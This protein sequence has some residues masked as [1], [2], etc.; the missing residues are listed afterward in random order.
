MKTTTQGLSIIVPSY[1]E[2]HTVETLVQ[3]IADVL[4]RSDTPYEIIFVDDHSK[5]ATKQKI[6]NLV[7][8]YPIKVFTK[9]GKRGKAYSITEGATHA[10][11]EY[12]AMLDADLQ[13]PPEALPALFA[14]AQKK[15]M[16]VAYRK[17]YRTT[18]LRRIASRL[19][20]FIFG[21]LLLDLNTDVQSGL[22]IF[23]REIF[24][25]LNRRLVS[26]WA[27]DM[28]LL[29]TGYELGFTI[30]HVNIDFHPRISGESHVQLFETAKQ[31]AMGAIKTKLSRRR[32]FSL[33]PH[34]KDT[35]RGAG[36]AHR[37]QRFITHTTLPHHISAFTTLTRWQKIFLGLL[38]LVIGFNLIS[39]PLTT[40]IVIVGVLSAVYFI[41]VLFNL[42]LILKSLHFPPEISIDAQELLNLKDRDLP[43]YSILCPLYREANILPQFVQ[44]IKSLDWLEE[45][46]DILLLLEEDDRATIDAA[47]VMKLP[48]SMRIVVVPHSEPKTKPKASNYG[49]SLVKGEYVVVYDAE[50]IPDP[51]QL[52]KAYLGFQKLPSSVVCLQAKLNYYNP[53]HNL[54]TR[55]FTAEYSLWFDVILPGLQSIDT[56]IPLGGTSNHFRTKDL[57]KLQGWDPFNVTE[58]CDL[59]ARL[60][61]QGYKTA[62]IDSTTLEEANSRVKNWF[63]QRSRWIKGYMQ[64]YFVHMRNPVS[65]AKTHSIHALI[66]QLV[67]G[68]RIAFMLINPFLWLAT[69]SYFALYAVVGPAI[70]A[71]YPSVVFYMAAFSLVF[72]NFIYL[73]NYMIGC[74]KRG[75][76]ELIK[77]VFFIPFYW[78]MISFGA[79]I[80]LF[81]LM[82]KP[83]YWEKTIHGLH[84]DRQERTGLGDMV[85]GKLAR[86]RG[87]KF[88]RIA[89]L[90]QSHIVG[91]GILV[92]SSMI[93]N[94]LNFIY[95][96]YLGR[97]VSLEDFGVVTLIGSFV[98]ISQVPL[99]SLARSVTHKS[100]YLFGQF[101]VPVKAFWMSIRR[102]SYIFAAIITLLWLVVV[103][104]LQLFFHIDTVIPFLLFTPVW[105]LG[106]LMAI[107]GGFLNGTLKF[108]VIATIVVVES[109]C[110]LVFSV[111]LV[112]QGVSQFVYA[113]IPLSMFVSF[114]VGWFFARK[115]STKSLP[116]GIVP[117]LAFPKR[118]FGT[119][120]LAAFT[121]VTYLSLDVLLAK[122][123][124][125]P[126]EAGTYGFLSL[127]GKMVYFLSTLFSGFITPVISREVGAGRKSARVFIKLFAFILLANTAAFLAFGILGFITVP[128]LWG[129][130]ATPVIPYLPSYALAMVAFSISAS[131]IT[132]HQV[133]GKYAFPIVG[134][135]LGLIEV[136]GIAFFH[137][138][139]QTI[140][141]VV[142]TASIIMLT[143]TALLDRLYGPIIYFYRNSIDFLGLFGRLPELAPLPHGNKRI[144]IFNW[145]DLKHRWSGGA[146][147]YIH[148]LAK[149]WVAMG[150]EVTVFCGNDGHSDRYETID[151]V[152]IIRRG[153]TYFV[154]VWALLY[155]RIRLKSKYDIIIDSENGI[156]FFTPM[157]AKEKV[158]L[159]IHHVHQDVFRKAL[160]PPLSW[161]GMFLER[162]L[163]PIAYRNTEVITVS[164][165]SKADILAHKLTKKEPYVLY[166]GVDLDICKP[167]K[168]NAR[169]MVLYLGRLTSLK[170]LPVLIHAAKKIVK[171]IPTVAIVIAGDG[172]EK[173][174]L[175]KLTKTLGLDKV[176]SFTGKV[177]ET[178]KIALYQ[179]AWVFVNPS[180]IEG[181]GIT[182][183]EANACGTPVVASNVAGLMDAVH[184][185]HSGVLVPYGN[186]D[187]FAANITSLLSDH[188]MRQRMSQESITWAQKFDW[189]KSA[190]DGIKII[191]NIKL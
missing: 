137:D 167:G 152:R 143:S 13:Y 53:H 34:T 117:S 128:M 17:T 90:S 180:L 49:L 67:V 183:I 6:Q 182:T 36:I 119:S 83:H 138:S 12:I 100:A 72:G 84:M 81:Q 80:A 98:Y 166:N 1:N 9:E 149:R 16:A 124:L 114:V 178:K 161:I 171:Q 88:Q 65:F 39:N 127:I 2:E 91:G 94:V 174:K 173:Q 144:L 110:K 145:R 151:G 95:N 66:F 77:Y 160:R 125:T 179:K 177:S 57:Q 3:R 164:P 102:K 169:P 52:K 33:P 78:L 61:K 59:G 189:D 135:F 28:P 25:H 159:L 18:F 5:D 165:S 106:T 170:S 60:F 56:T 70:E 20:A 172:P 103:P 157:Y 113:A 150:H 47:S 140:T 186:V 7:K 73:Y 104:V 176:I 8:K 89:D 76:W 141:Y 188:T 54:L 99:S 23:K 19:N 136:I 38:L 86:V 46:L 48:P 87:R 96:A 97:S 163:M 58:D 116:K 31:I 41:D 11:Y 132:Y 108:S 112:S 63:R 185:P 111:I 107:D 75:H 184:N 44:A 162:R 133:R 50:D 42:Y 24:D 130:K 4:G 21:G 68:G 115:I 71:M 129:E 74:A 139:I 15:G 105:F 40:G 109:A 10:R 29:F 158:Y 93:G 85:R 187:E 121:G 101:G 45:K 26:A 35:M 131:L 64:T 51:L 62:I 155:Y 191:Q 69:I 22:K 190:Q 126:T 181:W 30:G 14:I 153:G 154:Y 55:L 146:E 27:I 175:V 92:V 147:V 168:K 156:P 79:G 120:L 148:E 32:I 123:F 43:M 142:L 122:H 134:F 82:F 37:R 118:F